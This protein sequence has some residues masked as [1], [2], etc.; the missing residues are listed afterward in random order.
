MFIMIASSTR[1]LAAF[2]F[3]FSAGLA[4]AQEIP[5]MKMV[6]EIPEGLTTPDNIQTRMGGLNFFDGVPDI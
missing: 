4:L 2:T 3:L 6:T 1:V 5:A